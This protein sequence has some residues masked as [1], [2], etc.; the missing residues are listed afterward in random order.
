MMR[1]ALL[2]TG[3]PGAAEC[4]QAMEK[5]LGLHVDTVPDRRA[6][7]AALRREEYAVVILDENLALADAAATDVLWRQASLA[8]P[9]EINFA[10]CGCARITRE[11]RAALARRDQEQMLAIRAAATLVES[12]LNSAVTGLVLQ[13]ELAMRE[14]GITPAIAARLQTIR[15]IA[16]SLRDRL[17]LPATTQEAAKAALAR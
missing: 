4:A 5:Q 11:V 7:L 14:T 1:S 10:I 17:R 16:D 3:V 13:S 6:G 2:I 9:I 15:E 8:V 12:E